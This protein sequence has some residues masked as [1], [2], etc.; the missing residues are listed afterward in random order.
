MEYWT[1][2]YIALSTEKEI[3]DLLNKKFKKV[4]NRYV[5]QGNLKLSNNMRP[6]HLQKTSIVRETTR[7]RR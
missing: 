5:K 3:D 6:S 1:Y 2:R 4:K 7:T